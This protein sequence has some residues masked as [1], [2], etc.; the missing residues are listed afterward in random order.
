MRWL[1]SLWFR[2][3]RAKLMVVSVM[4]ILLPALVTMVVYN[5]LTRDAVKEQ[6]VSNAQQTLQLVNGHV[7]N[8]LNHMMY[9]CNYIQVVDPDMLLA[10]KQLSVGQFT[11]DNVIYEE[12]QA[13]RQ[14]TNTIDSLTYAGDRS[15]VTIVLNDAVFLM[16]YQI[17]DFDPKNLLKEPW[18]GDVKGLS[19]LNSYWVGTTPNAFEP[20]KK[21]SPYQLTVGRHLPEG[22][23]GYMVVTIL[24][25][26][27]HKYFK[28]IP[29]GHEMLLVDNNDRI[30][31]HIDSRRIGQHFPLLK[32]AQE[33]QSDIVTMQDKEYLITASEIKFNGWKLVSLTP[34]KS[35]ISKINAIF[36]NVFTF[37]LISFALFFVLLLVALRAFTSPLVKLDKVAVLVQKGDLDVRSSIRG[38]DEIGRLGKSFDQ[39]LDRISDMLVQVTLTQA[40]KR[41]AELNMLQAQIN[42]HFLFNV[43]NSIRMKVLGRGDKESADMISSLSKLLRMTIQDN[44]T[45]SLHEEVEIVVDYV[46]LMNMRQKQKVDLQLDVAVEVFLERVPRFFLQPIIE[47]ALIHGLSQQAGTIMLGAAAEDGGILIR[48]QDDGKGMEPEELAALQAKLSRYSAESEQAPETGKGFS[49]IGLANVYERLR[50]TFGQEFR[51]ELHSE[52]GAGTTVTL[53][54]PKQE[55]SAHV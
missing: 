38:Q 51:M 10:L 27:L 45:I 50:M 48:V 20:F 43:L 16:N 34:Y 39:M 6:A 15:F 33:R 17:A 18:I 49:G 1:R 4:C 40:R 32:Q 22:I 24:E 3:F 11:T 36:Q 29:E 2:S 31:S 53:F 25:S 9:L 47:N 5:Y 23:N 55:E 52:P 46:K 41:K 7:T 8:V 14:V 12:Y 35:A 42:P 26:D 21:I 30:L 44:G 37:Q 19:G 28:D 54:I 13:R